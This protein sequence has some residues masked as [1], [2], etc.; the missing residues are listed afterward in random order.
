MGIPIAF[1]Q[2][3]F[4]IGF[5]TSQPELITR[6]HSDLVNIFGPISETTLPIAFDHSSYYQ[7]EMGAPLYKHWVFFS[8]LQSPNTISSTKLETNRIEC[9]YSNESG[10]KINLDPGFLTPHNVVLLSTKNYAHRIP[11]Q[12]G[13]YAELEL[14]Y[15]QGHYQK[16]PWTYPD[17][18]LS[19]LQNS[20]QKNRLN[21]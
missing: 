11:L 7:E 13:I 3:V 14:I 17:Y 9:L 10:R 8:N 5:L 15:T 19:T 6:A 18:L 21:H 20:F 2:A 4:F 12:N 16:L 1:S